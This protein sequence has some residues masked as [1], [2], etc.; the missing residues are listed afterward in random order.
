[1]NSKSGFDKLQ[2]EILELV[3]ESQRPCTRDRFTTICWKL[4]DLQDAFHNL[5]PAYA[6]EVLGK[7]DKDERE[8]VLS[9]R[10]LIRERLGLS[11]EV[12]VSEEFFEE[13]DDRHHS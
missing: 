9:H 3:H 4:C 13:L 7:L 6:D 11:R 2:A 1:M 10:H 12:W 8:W 5:L